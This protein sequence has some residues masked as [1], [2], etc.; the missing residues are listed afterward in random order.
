M[1]DWLEENIQ[2]WPEWPFETQ[3]VLAKRIATI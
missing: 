3:T 1:W 2:N